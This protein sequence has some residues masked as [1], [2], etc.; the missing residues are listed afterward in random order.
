MSENIHGW[1]FFFSMAALIFIVQ[2]MHTSRQGGDIFYHA[3]KG[4]NQLTKVDNGEREVEKELVTRIMNGEEAMEE[5][6]PYQV[7]LQY[8]SN[9]RAIS[10]K[11]GHICGGSLLSS[12]WVMT[13]AHCVTVYTADVLYIVGGTVDISAQDTPVMKV[14]RIV[15]HQYDDRTKVNDIALLEIEPAQYTPISLCSSVFNPAGLDCVVSGW[16]H[17]HSTGSYTQDRL[18]KVS[19][20]VVHDQL[21]RKML[22][23]LPWDKN[24]M[25]CAGG[26]DKD[27]CQGDSGGPLVCQQDKD[28]PCIAGIVSWGVPCATR[29]VPGVYTRV[30]TYLP[31]IQN[32]TGI[33]SVDKS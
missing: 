29:G 30:N 5:E 14:V 22:R 26:E 25:L 1:S 23:G 7:S 15:R 28:N 24:T 11:E 19:L 27:A 6:L 21:C 32:I 12:T 20:R 16:G 2:G 4:R 18:R 31:W 8:R 10:N 13:A 9:N 33:I 17:T 3:E